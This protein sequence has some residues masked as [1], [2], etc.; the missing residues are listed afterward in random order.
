MFQLRTNAR[1]TPVGMVVSV[2][3]MWEDTRATVLRDGQ[4]STVKEVG[5]KKNFIFLT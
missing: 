4:E 5:H 1:V 3:T 2:G